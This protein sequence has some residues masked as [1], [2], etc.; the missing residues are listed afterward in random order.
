M[1]TGKCIH[2]RG[3]QHD[4]CEIGLDWREITGGDPVGIARRMP[5]IKQD[6]ESECESY[7]EP[8]DEQIKESEAEWKRL[9]ENMKIVSPLI[10]R[11]K[12]ENKNGGNGKIECPICNGILHYAVA[13]L[14][15][16]CHGKCET[17]GCL[18]WM[19]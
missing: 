2:F 16:H 3:I 19:E 14:N 9:I 1:R 8:T 18:N 10:S 13:A 4:T 12:K 7:C 5:C 15:N 17:D 11:L 6:S